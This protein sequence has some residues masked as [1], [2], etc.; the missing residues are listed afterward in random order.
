M[1]SKLIYHTNE[2]RNGGFS[3]FDKAIHQVSNSKELLIARPYIDLS[4]IKPFLRKQ[5]NWRIISDVEAWVSA[6]Q[7]KAREEIIDFLIENTCKIHHYRNL[8]AKV[9]LGDH[10]CLLG[11]ANLTIMGISHRAEMSILLNESNKINEIREWF[12]NSWLS[13]SEVNIPNLKDYLQKTTIITPI[14]ESHSIYLNSDAPIIKSKIIDPEEAE[15][16]ARKSKGIKLSEPEPWNGRDFYVNLGEGKH[17]NWADC[18]R[19]GFIS[20]GSE[21]KYNRPLIKLLS[22]GSR[23]F[24]YIPQTGYVGVGLVI[25]AAVPVR[26][27]KVLVNGQQVPILDA[28]TVAPSMDEYADDLNKSEYLV[29]VK[30]IK[31][32]SKSEAYRYETGLFTYPN[33]VCRM[34]SP[35]SRLTIEKLSQ[36]FELDD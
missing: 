24:V 11:S 31:K 26:D 32:V 1:S 36:Y 18:Q 8:H 9:F 20:G 23:L 21:E 25:H 3:P 22:P 33:I 35:R 17:R 5:A 7:S 16:K 19:Y 12:E 28:P 4:Y 30:W 13:S 34:E 27:F 15:Q 6:F 14:P 29:R 2:S 10:L